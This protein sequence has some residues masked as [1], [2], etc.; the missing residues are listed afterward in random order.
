M[1]VQNNNSKISACP[2]LATDLLQI[3]IPTILYPIV[4]KRAIYTSI[5][6]CHRRWSDRKI[7]GYYPKMSNLKIPHRKLRLSKKEVFRKNYVQ[8]TDW[9]GSGKSLLGYMLVLHLL[10]VKDACLYII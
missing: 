9:T 1:A 8:E 5:Q 3:L 10:T 7:F 2:D 6:P 4:S